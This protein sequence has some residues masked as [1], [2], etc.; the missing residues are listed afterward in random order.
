MKSIEFTTPKGA[1]SLVNSWHKLT[2]DAYLA[3]LADILCYANGKLSPAMVKVNYVCRSLGINPRKMK[4]ED[5]LANLTWLAEQVTFPFIIVYP[6]DDEAIKG[7]D[8]EHYN[9]FKRMPPERID[10]PMAR[11]LSRLEYKFAV[12]SI[13]CAQLLPV[14][15]IPCRPFLRRCKEYK[16]YTIDTSHGILTS[17]MTAL[18]WVE[19]RQ[20][21]DGSR[22]KLALLA[23]MLYCPAPYS[24][25]KAQRLADDFAKLP[26]V[27]L[28]AIAFNFNAF[29]NYLFTA[30]DFSILAA[31]RD[32]KKGISTGPEA[33]L[34]NLSADGLGSNEE[35]EQMSVIKYFTILRKKLIE[36]VRSLSSAGM[37]ISDIEKETG[38]PLPII[39]KIL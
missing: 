20:I 33:S 1:Y 39:S 21:S 19:S 31:G 34:Y 24:S 14:I 18:Q 10:N 29:N 32:T 16:A 38:L 27:T 37:K 8:K 36:S 22:D 9:L 35:I 12:D 6:N 17:S 25:E 11:Y 3:L 28:Q 5:A 15:K 26:D 13:F 7:T 23:A 2:P 4:N 30:T